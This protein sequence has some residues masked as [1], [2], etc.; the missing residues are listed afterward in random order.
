MNEIRILSGSDS[1]LAR[2]VLAGIVALPFAGYT[3]L[4]VYQQLRSGFDL[5]GAVF[6]SGT[7][8]VAI[9]CGWF[10]LRGHVAESRARIW[11][12]VIGGVV[13]GSI[14][15]TVGFLGPLILTPSANQ[16]PLLGIFVTG[17]LGFEIG[18]AIG[19][20]CGRSRAKKPGAR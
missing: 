3:L 12:S 18:A 5:L 14:G 11:L 10:A 16:G 7:G 4:A 13:L 1:F 15:F 8:T 6:A 20:L 2:R 9:L 17:P 19:W